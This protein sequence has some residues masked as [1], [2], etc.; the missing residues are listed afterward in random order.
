MQRQAESVYQQ[1]SAISVALNPASNSLLPAQQASVGY[2]SAPATQRLAAT[3]SRADG[4]LR[5][6]GVDPY[7]TKDGPI[8]AEEFHWATISLLKSLQPSQAIPEWVKR[9]VEPAFMDQAGVAA[10]ARTVSNAATAVLAAYPTAAQ[11]ATKAYP[12]PTPVGSPATDKPVHPDPHNYSVEELRWNDW[13]Q[14]KPTPAVGGAAASL[15]WGGIPGPAQPQLPSSTT[16]PNTPTFPTPV[17]TL[18]PPTPPAGAAAVFPS[19]ESMDTSVT[20]DLVQHF[21]CI[22]A[23]QSS[24]MASP[25]EMRVVQVSTAFHSCVLVCSWICFCC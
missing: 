6:V 4:V 24:S 7:F 18:F 16:V 15:P 22:Y 8:S 2:V 21:Q 19:G 1:P 5:H 13:L 9:T 14:K 23:Q 17:R 3:Q 11:A 25:E 20:P 12:T 10:P